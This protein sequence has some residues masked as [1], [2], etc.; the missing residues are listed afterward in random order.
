[1]KKQ[2]ALTVKEIERK[3]F[4]NGIVVDKKFFRGKRRI[5]DNNDNLEEIGFIKQAPEVTYTL[6]LYDIC[7]SHKYLIAA[8]EAI[9]FVVEDT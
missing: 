3:L 9:L 4:A 6:C 5:K 7:T 1:M 2:R 8:Y